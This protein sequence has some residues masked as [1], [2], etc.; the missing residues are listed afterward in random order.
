VRVLISGYYGFGNLG[1]EMLLQVIVDGLRRRFPPVLLEVLSATP[2]ATAAS[3]RVEAVPRWDRR[4]ICAA[5]ARS[6]V[7]L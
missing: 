6:D 5:I 1:D 3:R 2:L 4:S 7:V